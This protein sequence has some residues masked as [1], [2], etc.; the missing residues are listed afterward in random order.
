MR[1]YGFVATAIHPLCIIHTTTG[2]VGAVSIIKGVVLMLFELYE[3][4][5]KIGFINTIKNDIRFIWV[6]PEKRRC[7]IA[8]KLLDAVLNEYDYVTFNTLSED[9]ERFFKSLEV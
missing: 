4:D 6:I 2:S 7:G 8:T 3:D 1:I 5:I 9:G